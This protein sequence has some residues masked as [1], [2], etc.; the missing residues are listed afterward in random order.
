MVKRI[1]DW[2]LSISCHNLALVFDVFQSAYKP[3]LR[4]FAA[5]PLLYRLLIWLVLSAMSEVYTEDKRHM[6][7]TFA[8]II[9]LAIHSLVQPY[10]K[11]KHN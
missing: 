4:F 11:P 10:K 7:I 6:Y 9:F 2:S 5:L 3:N 8:F 1:T